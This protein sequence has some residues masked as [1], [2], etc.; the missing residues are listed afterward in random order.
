MGSVSNWAEEYPQQQDEEKLLHMADGKICECYM[1][2][3]REDITWGHYMRTLSGGID[4]F[5]NLD[6]CHSTVTFSEISL[7]C[8]LQCKLANRILYLW[9]KGI[10]ESSMTN[11]CTVS[12]RKIDKYSGRKIY[13][14]QCE[15]C[16]LEY[17]SYLFLFHHTNFHDIYI[18]IY[19]LKTVYHILLALF[20]R[21][22]GH[23]ITLVSFELS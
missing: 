10:W 6:R 3:S 22:Q 4:S 18:Y 23:G 17:S 19:K 1:R 11:L 16:L 5:C 2:T 14:G 15:K 8:E 13:A 21:L 20:R 9:Q 7:V 12:A